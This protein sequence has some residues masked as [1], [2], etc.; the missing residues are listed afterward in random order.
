MI[1]TLGADIID[2]FIES[3]ELGFKILRVSFCGFKQIPPN[4]P[5]P[6][7]NIHQKLQIS[8]TTLHSFRKLYHFRH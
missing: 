2:F 5:L 6:Q 1:Y 3:V 8:T 7:H 4:L